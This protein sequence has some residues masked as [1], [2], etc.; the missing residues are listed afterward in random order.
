[1]TSYKERWDEATYNLGVWCAISVLFAKGWFLLGV[2]ATILFSI[3]IQNMRLYYSVRLI[4]PN[5]ASWVLLSLSFLG[6][7]CWTV[8]K[9]EIDTV[10][11]FVMAFPV[12]IYAYYFSTRKMRSIFN[13]NKK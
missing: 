2:V 10:W 11:R 13:E 4:Y 9:L 6:V 3:C 7:G 12:F 5:I 8:N 1:M